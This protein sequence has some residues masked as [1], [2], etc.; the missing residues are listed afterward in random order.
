MFYLILTGD[1]SYV[2]H[3][4]EGI[5]K[6]DK[7]SQGKEQETGID[8]LYPPRLLYLFVLCCD[9]LGEQ[10]S[11][12]FTFATDWMGFGKKGFEARA[13]KEKKL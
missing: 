8:F 11:K 9:G 2:S 4:V 1:S 12:C 6:P 10:A 13:S 5:L 7:G 3:S